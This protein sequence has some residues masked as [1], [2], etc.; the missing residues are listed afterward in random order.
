MGGHFWQTCVCARVCT[1]VHVC[2]RTC[3]DTR[4]E[5]L[6]HAGQ[7]GVSGGPG[8]AQSAQEHCPSSREQTIQSVL[9]PSGALVPWPGKCGGEGRQRRRGGH[10]RTPPDL[11]GEK[12]THSGKYKTN[13]KP[14][15]LPW[16]QPRFP[17][18]R[19]LKSNSLCETGSGI[20]TL[21][22]DRSPEMFNPLVEC[23]LEITWSS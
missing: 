3:G 6:P 20:Y 12:E 21:A 9:N 8:E 10:K 19:I 1:R 4:R 13:Q 15:H 11:E 2:A 17:S 23:L 18:K 22:S 5:A 16:L 7:K 14:D